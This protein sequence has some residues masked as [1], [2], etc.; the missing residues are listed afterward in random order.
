M[1]GRWRRSKSVLER[2]RLAVHV[3]RGAVLDQVAERGSA[4]RAGGCYG[5]NAGA[6]RGG[7]AKRFQEVGFA[8]DLEIATGGCLDEELPRTVDRGSGLAGVGREGG[9]TAADRR[10][11]HAAG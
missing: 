9:C 4:G 3:Q 6:E 7:Q 10:G 5:G 11:L 8:A 2:D 1:G